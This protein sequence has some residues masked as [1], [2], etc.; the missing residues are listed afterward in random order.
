[1]GNAPDSF[2]TVDGARSGERDFSPELQLCREF[3]KGGEVGAA[4]DKPT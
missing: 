4:S 3:Y 1:M 2:E